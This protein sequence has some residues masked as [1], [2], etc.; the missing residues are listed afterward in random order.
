MM[1]RYTLFFFCLKD[2]FSMR[3]RDQADPTGV[4]K[5]EGTW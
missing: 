3:G 2:A 5:A 4:Q 1:M